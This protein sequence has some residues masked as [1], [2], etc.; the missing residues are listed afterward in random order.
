MNITLNRLRLS[1][2]LTAVGLSV[3]LGSTGAAA[4]AHV[5]GENAQDGAAGTAPAPVCKANPCSAE[6]TA[7]RPGMHRES[8]RAQQW[9]R[10]AWSREIIVSDAGSLGVQTAWCDAEALDCTIRR[11]HVISSY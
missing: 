3:V 11:H 7:S 9:V 6:D 10:D 8:V 5:P 2:A 1:A 4:T